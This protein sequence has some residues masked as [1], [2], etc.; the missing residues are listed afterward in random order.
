MIDKVLALEEI[1]H[2]V[3]KWLDEEISAEEAISNVDYVLIKY[4]I[5]ECGGI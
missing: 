2:E 5:Y 3:K 4:N 1:K